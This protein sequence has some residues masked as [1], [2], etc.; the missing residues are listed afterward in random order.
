MK[1]NLFT[2]N[3]VTLCVS[4]MNKSIKFYENFG[5]A[6]E[7]QYETEETKIVWMKSNNI[8]LEMFWYKTHEELPEHSKTLNKDLMTIGNK[9][10]GLGVKSLEEAIEFIKKNN[11][12]DNEIIINEGRM[13]KRYFFIKDPDNILFEIIEEK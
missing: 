7:K 11:L 9:H 10:F 6:I 2:F 3:H 4:D 5:F 1:E 12:Y 8:I 13:G